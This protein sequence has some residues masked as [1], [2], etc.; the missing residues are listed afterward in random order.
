ML[1]GDRFLWLGS[2]AKIFYW[3]QL[4]FIRRGDR[5]TITTFPGESFDNPYTLNTVDICP[6]GALTSKDFRFKSRVWDMS[7]TKSICVG[8]SRGCNIEIGVRNN[9][10]LRLPLCFGKDNSKDWSEMKL[11][12]I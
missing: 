1:L 6:V 12:R 8:C 10:I 2:L 3:N 9:E 4:T 7:H 11:T 5:V